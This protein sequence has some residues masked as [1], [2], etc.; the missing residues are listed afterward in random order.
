[1]YLLESV[2]IGVS[3]AMDAFAICLCQGLL[4]KENKV[5]VA[6]KFGITFGLFQVVMP[7]LGF[8]IGSIFSDRVS[9]YGNIVA[10]VIL[11]II[12]INMIRESGEEQCEVIVGI[13]SLLTL[14]VA[15]SIDAL[16][17]G[18]SFAMNG[19]KMILIPALIIGIVTLIISF[20]GTTLGNKLGSILGNKAHYLGGTI[21]ILL[22]IKALISNFI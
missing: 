7:L 5:A 18:L 17:V 6:L 2:L 16:A 21:L 12:G 13:K 4:I 20:L 9:T 3:L 19:E 1:M 8:Y 15:T 14:G 22:G 11:L 10:F